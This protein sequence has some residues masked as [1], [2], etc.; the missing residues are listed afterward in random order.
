M[1][2]LRLMGR[3][4]PAILYLTGA[5]VVISLPPVRR[6]LRSAAVMTAKGVLAVAGGV[7]VGQEMVSE[8]VNDIVEEA[9]QTDACPEARVA[10]KIDRLRHKM[11]HHGR[12]LA[13]A[14]AAGAL[15]VAGTAKPIVDEFHDIVKEAKA[16]N[17]K[18]DDA[19]TKKHDEGI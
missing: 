8:K 10:E 19:D 1:N 9:K 11:R 16:K 12:R 15:S 14:T 18:S 3:V 13:V 4:S 6:M 17:E 5:A 2:I 7:K